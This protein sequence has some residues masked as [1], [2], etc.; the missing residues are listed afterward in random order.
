MIALTLAAVVVTV[1]HPI[2]WS[3]EEVRF[4]VGAPV[5][6]WARSWL[7]LSRSPIGPHAASP[8]PSGPSQ[9]RRCTSRLACSRRRWLVAL[10]FCA[11]RRAG[12]GPL[13]PPPGP[14]TRSCSLRHRRRRPRAGCGSGSRLGLPA[15]WMV[16]CLLG[17]SRSPSTSSRTCRGSMLD[18][19]RLVAGLAAGQ[20]GPDAA[21]ADAGRCTT[22]TTTCARARRVVALVGL[23]VRPQAGLVL[24]G[25]LRRQHGGVDLRRRQPRDLVAG[26]PGMAFCAWQAWKRRSLALA[27]IVIGFACQWLPGRGSTGRPSSTTTTRA[28]RS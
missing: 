22:T 5:G 13:A 28:C 1:L 11:G 24:P 4:A 10:A 7:L 12:F 17:L 9:P 27:L 20:H 8:W 3:V 23:A 15:A 16:V 25:L 26:D 21:R 2:A 6:D 18:G 14:T 19:N